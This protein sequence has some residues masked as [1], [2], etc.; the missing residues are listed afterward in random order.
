MAYIM[1]DCEKVGLSFY[2]VEK[3]S[4]QE[5]LILE[6]LQ[7]MFEKQHKKIE[8]QRKEIEQMRRSMFWESRVVCLQAM[9]GHGERR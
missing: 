5:E 3:G 7:S 8:Q 2:D 9:I 4:V 1:A 6:E